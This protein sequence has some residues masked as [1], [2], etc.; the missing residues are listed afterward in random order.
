MKEALAKAFCEAAGLYQWDATPEPMKQWYRSGIDA[1]LKAMREPTEKMK[2]AAVEADCESEYPSVH[3][4]L[5]A[6]IDEA[7]K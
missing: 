2:D 5:Q 6:M 1:V 3:Q 4:I 7:M